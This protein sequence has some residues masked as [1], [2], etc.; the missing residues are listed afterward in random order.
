MQNLLLQIK[1]CSV[2]WADKGPDTIFLYPEIESPYQD[3][4]VSAVCEMR[5]QNGYGVEYCMKVLGLEPD[6]IDLLGDM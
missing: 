4:R 2:Q 3:K 1:R 6:V 5:V